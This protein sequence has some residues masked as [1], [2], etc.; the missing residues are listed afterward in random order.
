MTEGVEVLVAGQA[1][2]MMEIGVALDQLAGAASAEEVRGDLLT[3]TRRNRRRAG[4][5]QSRSR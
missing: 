1:A 5:A 2:D 4:A 3:L